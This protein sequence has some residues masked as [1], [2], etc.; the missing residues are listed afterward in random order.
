MSV[1]WGKNCGIQT[2]GWTNKAFLGEGRKRSQ[3]GLVHNIFCNRLKSQLAPVKVSKCSFESF[4]AWCVPSEPTYHLHLSMKVMKVTRMTMLTKFHSMAR[5]A[6]MVVMVMMVV[7]NLLLRSKS[8]SS[9]CLAVPTTHLWRSSFGAQHDQRD[10][11]GDDDLNMW[12]K[13]SV[14][15]APVLTRMMMMCKD[16]AHRNMENN[17][18]STLFSCVV[19][20]S[21][22]VATL[23][24]N[25][26]SASKSKSDFHRD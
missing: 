6:I 8:P 13:V 1:R 18:R 16:C 9:L 7:K 17:M 15:V 10:H 19:K 23:I 25:S 22:I 5:M 3:F 4:V 2:D 20:A 21:V 24:H 11:H 26:T 14:N 12:V